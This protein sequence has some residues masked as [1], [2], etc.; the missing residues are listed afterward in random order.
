MK[1]L[2]F[3]GKLAAAALLPMLLAGLVLSACSDNSGDG[4]D[5]LRTFTYYGESGEGIVEI[6]FS[7]K[8][9]AASAN[10]AGPKDG[11][12]YM[13]KLN[14]DLI[15]SGRVTISSSGG[16]ITFVPSAS[17]SSQFSGTL[18]VN[19]ALAVPAIPLTGGGTIGLP[20][21]NPSAATVSTT[22]GASIQTFSPDYEGITSSGFSIRPSTAA[23]VSS[24][25]NTG[26]TAEYA[27]G[28]NNT[29]PLT[30]WQ[31]GLEFTGLDASTVYY[32]W[33]RSG[34][35]VT[36]TTNYFPGTAVKGENTVKT[37]ASAEDLMDKLNDLV[38]GAAE[39]GDV[40][41]VILTGT[42]TVNDELEIEQG[43]TLIVNGALNIADGGRL[44][45][46]G[47]VDIG[48]G[49]WT[50]K[51]ASVTLGEN[52]T[53]IVP[54]GANEDTLNAAIAQIKDI[55]RGAGP[56][57]SGVV[58][59]QL[60]PAFYNTVTTNYI[61]VDPGEDENTIPYTIRGLGKDFGGN[62]NKIIPKLGVGMWLAN[63]NITLEEVNFNVSGI[64]GGL[65]PARPWTK[66]AQGN[67]TGA[68]GVGVLLARAK[69][70]DGEAGDFIGGSKNVTVQ[71]CT[72]TIVG[73]SAGE[74]FTGGIWVYGSP[75]D[76]KILD[77][78]VNITGRGGNAVQALAFE[79][80]GDGI[81]VKNNK[82]TAK[83]ADQPDLSGLG[84]DDFYTG[85]ASAFFIG[86]FYEKPVTGA[87]RYSAGDISGNVL[88]YNP[89]KASVFSFYVRAYPRPLPESAENGG[90]LGV[91]AMGS[92]KF[93]ASLT[94]WALDDAAAGDYHRL[95]VGDLLNDCK[96]T[97]DGAAKNGFG[98]VL[99]YV[100]YGDP[101]NTDDYN[102]ETYKIAG[103]K[104]AN[105]G[106]HALPL[107]DDG[108]YIQ[109][110]IVDKNIIVNADG[111]TTQG[112][113]TH[114]KYWK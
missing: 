102:I 34:A 108:K 62:P 55:D 88:S 50:G 80:W 37:A 77:N 30:G 52:G 24:G 29:V 90:R 72:V 110:E 49:T 54:S 53:L 73:G 9:L 25:P 41:T 6:A 60:T 66:D 89:Q 40:S 33:A 16:D 111:T 42:V 51:G 64:T 45:I 84:N 36:T 47:T 28:K 59:I 44:N 101:D 15:S 27:A 4:T 103:G 12:Y 95:V 23:A 81:Q 14:G 11:D 1:K 70:G 113:G 7:S 8:P 76:I 35:K 57:Y 38:S 63:N 78:T 98:A 112:A 26:Q 56:D 91:T 20:S 100:S 87:Y 13:I 5:G 69:A 58:V 104:L 109:G 31:K 3:F 97:G 74:S 105:I 10:A 71:N 61:A 85:P 67:I 86:G 82:L 99:M 68:Y 22:Q 17:G 94:R 21:M 96:L 2:W 75:R 93:G 79:D 19:G 106:I 107:T 92:K 39:L 32:V 114:L 43:L 18:G 83:F 48:A 65:L 46:D